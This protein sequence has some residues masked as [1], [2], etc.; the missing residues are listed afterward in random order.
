MPVTLTASGSSREK[1]IS[2]TSR[3]TDNGAVAFA[4]PMD[5]RNYLNPKHFNKPYALWI[6]IVDL[7]KEG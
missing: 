6:K 1:T 3:R 4:L 7:K 2:S 5:C